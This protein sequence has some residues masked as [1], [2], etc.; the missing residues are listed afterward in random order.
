MED[1]VTSFFTHLAS[2]VA[3]PSSQSHLAV[4]LTKYVSTFTYYANATTTFSFLLGEPIAMVLAYNYFDNWNLTTIAWFGAY[5]AMAIYS[6]ML[7]AGDAR[8]QVR[9]LELKV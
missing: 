9:V 4:Q 6:L 1:Q 5:Y 8:L 7:I 2:V 3:E